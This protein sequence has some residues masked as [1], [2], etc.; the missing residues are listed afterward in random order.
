[1]NEAIAVF[2]MML[3]VGD[4]ESDLELGELLPLRWEG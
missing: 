4:G 1:M 3:G 2:G